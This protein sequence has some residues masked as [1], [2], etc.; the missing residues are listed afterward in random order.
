MG[1]KGKGKGE[2][3]M[4]GRGCMEKGKGK[5]MGDADFRHADK[6]KGKGEDDFMEKGKGKGEADFMNSRDCKG[7]GKGPDMWKG[8]G[9]GDGTSC[10]YDSFAEHR[11]G[12]YDSFSTNAPMAGSFAVGAP[13]R[14]S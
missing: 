12:S 5:R 9:K 6:G 14:M 13:N 7:S 2:Q 1:G 11:L 3:W 4:D 10:S 8:K